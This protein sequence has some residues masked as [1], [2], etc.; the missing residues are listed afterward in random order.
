MLSDATQVES[1]PVGHIGH[2]SSN[3]TS[4]LYWV[5]QDARSLPTGC[6]VGAWVFTEHPSE[7]K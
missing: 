5:C 4:P 7:E 1:R 2:S 3:K 6:K